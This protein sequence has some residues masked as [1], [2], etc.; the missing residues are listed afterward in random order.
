MANSIHR[1]RYA[2]LPLV[3]AC[4]LAS[5]QDTEPS[6]ISLDAESSSFN[7]QNNTVEFRVLSIAQDGMRIRADH[8]V[9]SALDF[10]QSDWRFTGNV[11]LTFE[12]ATIRAVSAEIMFVAHELQT[13][14]LTGEPATFEDSSQGTDEPIRGG[15]AQLS[16]DNVGRV[17]HMSQGA[18]LS[19]GPNE[20]R[21]CDLIYDLDQ[22]T[23]TSGSSDCGEPVVITIL[24]PAGENE[25]ESS[26]SP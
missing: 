23:I 19:Q 18:W 14:E 16:Y 6:P 1:R 21:G 24:P 25:T 22:E 11:V 3:L 15:A 26:P 7:R 5:A 13:A 10:E 9:A 20:F 2:I 4:M 17:I 8:A 12:S